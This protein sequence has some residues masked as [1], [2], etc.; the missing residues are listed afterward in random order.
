MYVTTFIQDWWWLLAFGM[1]L[2]LI[3]VAALYT[4]GW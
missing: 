2:I 4:E 1:A 3:V